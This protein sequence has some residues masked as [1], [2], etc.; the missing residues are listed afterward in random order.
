MG[1]KEIEQFSISYMDVLDEEGGADETLLPELGDEALLELY[2]YMLLAR[3]ADMRMLNLQRQGRLGT[4][5]TSIGQEAAACGPAFALGEQDWLVP[6]FR[7]MGALLVRRVALS[8][9]YLYYK[10]YEEGNINADNPRTLPACIP[11]ASQLTQAVGIAYAMRYLGEKNS[12]VLAF[13]GDGGTSEGD[14]HE[15]LNMA[16]VWNTPNVFVIQNNCYALSMHVEHQTASKTLAQK[17]LAYGIHG[18]RV[19]G[20]DALAMVAATRQALERAKSG[21]GPTLIEAMTY[22]IESH[23][24]ADDAARYRP[25][26]ELEEWIKKDPIK[27]YATFLRKQKLLDDE[28]QDSLDEAVK[29]KVDA[30]VSDFESR[31]K[32]MKPD[33]PFDFVYAVP[34][35]EIETQRER[36]LSRSDVQEAVKAYKETQSG[37]GEKKAESESTKEGRQN[38]DADRKK[39]REK[40]TAA[41]SGTETKGQSGKQKQNGSGGGKK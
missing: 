15:A 20:N 39:P 31:D 34:P 19:D 35:A 27:R 40:R 17:A 1:L 7:E 36:F 6:S 33:A 38:D 5:I 2:K 23:S 21:E 11:I 30:A 28:K 12:A 8:N 22:R 3:A 29:A 32:A 26:E 4:A 18:L 10:G 9:I 16:G 13:V 25:E 24:T 14:F 37:Q 41:E